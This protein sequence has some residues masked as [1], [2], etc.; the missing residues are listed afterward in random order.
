MYVE[1]FSEVSKDFWFVIHKIVCTLKITQL[2]MKRRKLNYLEGEISNLNEQEKED[3]LLENDSNRE[4]QFSKGFTSDPL[5]CSIPFAFAYYY[6]IYQVISI[7][8]RFMKKIGFLTNIV[9]ILRLENLA[10]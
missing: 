7:P 4:T 1:G 10:I 6:N 9:R 8:N 5:I 2:K 3:L